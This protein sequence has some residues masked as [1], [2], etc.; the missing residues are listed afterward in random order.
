M[1]SIQALEDCT[2][3]VFPEAE[4]TQLRYQY[5]DLRIFGSKIIET[6]LVRK[7]RKEIILA[8]QKFSDL[9]AFFQEA[10]PDLEQRVPQY[11]IASYLG[12]D[13]VSLSRMKG[14]I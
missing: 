8:T 10:Y 1:I 14:R 9:Y 7:S 3:L 6:E 12:V 13:P 4:F 11:Y 2:L 5:P